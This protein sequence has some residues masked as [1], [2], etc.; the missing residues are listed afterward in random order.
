[1]GS[2]T[3]LKVFISKWY[4]SIEENH[5]RRTKEHTNEPIETS[6]PDI[7]GQRIRYSHINNIAGVM[8]A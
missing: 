3:K 2:N 8:T 7:M 5:T 4:I 1:M 6:R